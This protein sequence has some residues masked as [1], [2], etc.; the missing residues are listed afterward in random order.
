MVGYNNDES[1]RG[2]GSKTIQAILYSD[3]IMR[4]H[5]GA[6]FLLVIVKAQHSKNTIN[7]CNEFEKFLSM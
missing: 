2:I 1:I 6:D 7:N 3:D 5:N 4:M